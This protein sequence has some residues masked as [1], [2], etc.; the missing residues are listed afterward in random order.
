MYEFMI[1]LVK[2]RA[3]VLSM[4]EKSSRRETNL[5][6]GDIEALVRQLSEVE[7]CL[8]TIENNFIFL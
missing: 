7:S 8:E 6:V 1:S 5:K 2:D 3:S 4:I